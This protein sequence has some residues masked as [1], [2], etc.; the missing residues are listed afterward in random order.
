MRESLLVRLLP[1]PNFLLMPTFG[2]DISDK[3]IRVVYLKETSHGL[4][5]GYIAEYFI[6]EGIVVNG[7]V[8]NV[9]EL[10]RLFADVVKLYDMRYITLSLPEDLSY[11][12]TMA[13]P[14]ASM[15]N[16]RES[17]ELQLEE[18]VP[19]EVKDVFF[20]ADIYKKPTTKTDMLEV[21]VG[22][23][24]K[25]EVINSLELCKK[26]GVLL[27]SIEIES[28]ATARSLVK[29]DDLGTYMIIDFGNR[30]A[31]FSV[32]S[33]GV[34]VS[35][36]S[37]PSLGG[38]ALMR[39][40]Q[41]KL[42]ISQAEAEKIKDEQ[43]LT[44]LDKSSD[45]YFS[46]M[47]HISSLR[48]EI[49]TRLDYWKTRKRGIVDPK[50]V[51]KIILCGEQACIPGIIDYLS[52][53]LDLEVELGNPWVNVIDFDKTLPPLNKKESTRFAKAI[54]LALRHIAYGH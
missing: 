3:V 1:P 28:Q 23:T 51:T 12:F 29:R 20:D 39:V 34:V 16:A 14:Q 10:T 42:N 53:S 8:E 44:G 18:Y 52:E 35:T 40:I 5:V 50:P 7:R 6:P 17:I 41:R 4:K 48:D 33:K 25:R 24:S 37:I 49:T 38:D 13:L 15:A 54:G 30:R 19:V 11:I 36:S 22:V 32:V 47:A 9:E 26:V 43:G 45:L 2:V 27:R 46:M 21:V 31:S